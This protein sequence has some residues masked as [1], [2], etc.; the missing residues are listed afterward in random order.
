MAALEL[1]RVSKRFGA[2]AVVDD[3]SLRVDDGELVVLV[4]P[5]GCGKSTLLRIVAGL[6]EPSAGEVLLDG[7]RVTDRE[8]RERDVAMVFQNYALYPHKT[9]RKNLAF[10]LEV[11]RLPR[12]E[13][14]RRVGAAAEL[15]GLA[16]LLER[17]P[18]ALSGGQMQRVALGRA[19]VREPRLFLF[20]EPLSNLDAKLRAEMRAEIARLHRRLGVTTLYVTHDQAEAMT[21]GRRIA[22]L[23]RGRL[24]QVGAP[25]EVYARPRTAF[26]A[27][28]IGSPA[29]SLLS[30]SVSGGGVDLGGA[31]FDAPRGTRARVLVGVR[32]HDA[33]L[34]GGGDVSARVAHV[35]RLGA[36]AL[37][38]CALDDG[39]EI[40]AA[41]DGTAA[42][43]AGDA[44]RLAIAR[45]ALHWFDAETGERV[46]D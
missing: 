6:V 8:P 33:R 41:L 16:E 12:A 23:E 26:V 42:C 21:L 4:G 10:P 38:T 46:E 25:L 36:Q 3:V 19:I 22:V 7:V 30:R 28:F 40:A 29:M 45:G 35:E 5:S 18:G 20:D 34:D 2:S 17:K 31:R 37:A 15:L 14:E 39:G 24:L 27:A 9:V 13:I 43:A 32:P 44:V 1:V 11:A